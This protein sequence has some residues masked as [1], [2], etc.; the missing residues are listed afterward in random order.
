M[1]I[2]SLPTPV[3]MSNFCNAK[4]DTKKNNF[5]TFSISDVT[6]N[7]DKTNEK[8][9]SETFKGEN[10]KPKTTWLHKYAN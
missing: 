1:D 3:E 7:L 2:K 6:Y 4:N 10:K 9:K 5:T 8:K